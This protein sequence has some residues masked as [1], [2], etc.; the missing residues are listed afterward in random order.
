MTGDDIAA[1]VLLRDDGERARRRAARI[2][3]LGDGVGE[4][5]RMFVVPAARGRGLLARGADGARAASRASEG[6]RRL[7]LET[8][9]LQ[10]AGDR[11]VPVGRATARSRTSASTPT[12]TSSRCFAKDLHAEPRREAPKH[13]GARSTLRRVPWDHPDAVALR[14]AMWLDIE[15]RYPEFVDGR[16][17]AASLRRPATG[18]RHD[19]LRCS[20]DLDGVPGRLRVAAGRGRRLPRG[21]R[22]AQEGL[23]RRRGARRRRRPRAAG[24]DRGRRPRGRPDQRRPADR[25]P[26]ARGRHALPVSAGYRPDRARSARTRTTSSRCCF[27]KDL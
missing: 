22:R 20:R 3:D 24:R 16:P 6:L 21:L 11:P 26:A 15:V 9:V 19:Q 13:A 14:Y 17:L 1:M 7:V 8:G 25:H 4:L 12:E 18:R 5:K 27:A 2:R 23:G 10:V